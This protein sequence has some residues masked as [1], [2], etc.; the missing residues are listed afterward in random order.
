LR[1]QAQLI[2]GD[3]QIDSTPNLGTTLVITLRMAPEEL[4]PLANEALRAS[5]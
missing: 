1:E 5:R 3:L 2:D 4:Q